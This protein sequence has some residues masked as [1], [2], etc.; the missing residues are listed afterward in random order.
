MGAETGVLVGGKLA[1]LR[2]SHGLIVRQVKSS[3][4]I[5]YN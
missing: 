1:I 2:C 4:A 5:M 3:T